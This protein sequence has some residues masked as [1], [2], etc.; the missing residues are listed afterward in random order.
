MRTLEFGF[1]ESAGEI[2]F[3]VV[4]TNPLESVWL[5]RV[6]HVLELGPAY[7]LLEILTGDFCQN[8]LKINSWFLAKGED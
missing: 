8:D 6:G 7:F 3:R 4:M 2:K 1:I 5:T